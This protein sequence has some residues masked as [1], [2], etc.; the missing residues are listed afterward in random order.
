MRLRF[1]MHVYELRPRNDKRGV[2]LISEV[3][4]FGRLWYGDFVPRLSVTPFN[5][6]CG[7]NRVGSDYG[8][9]AKS[10]SPERL[11]RALGHGNSLRTATHFGGVARSCYGFCDC[12]AHPTQKEETGG[13]APLSSPSAQDC[14]LE[15]ETFS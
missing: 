11:A 6:V 1:P 5:G 13:T 7:N 14:K 8:D 2:D 4:P 12:T 10:R 3:L 9:D 15:Q